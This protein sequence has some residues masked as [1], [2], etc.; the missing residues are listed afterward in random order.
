MKALKSTP[1]LARYHCGFSISRWAGRMKEGKGKL[2]RRAT[3]SSRAL[4]KRQ[5]SNGYR[6]ISRLAMREK[7]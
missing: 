1:W 6:K 2:E 3:G 4:A 7:L 5:E